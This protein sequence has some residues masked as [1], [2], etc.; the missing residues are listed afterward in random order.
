MD[1]RKVVVGESKPEL[2]DDEA[3]R[4][5]HR[6]VER[7]LEVHSSAGDS[8]ITVEVR[9]L[10]RAREVDPAI[11]FRKPRGR[12]ELGKSGVGKVLRRD[13]PVQHLV[14]LHAPAHPEPGSGVDEIRALRQVG[15]GAVRE[16]GAEVPQVVVVGCPL[17]VD[18]RR[19]ARG[20]G[21]VMPNRERGALVA[22]LAIVGHVL[23]RHPPAPPGHQVAVLAGGLH[24]AFVQPAEAESRVPVGS[25]VEVVGRAELEAV[26]IGNP[27]SGREKAGAAGVAQRE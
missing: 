11:A 17:V 10:R 7:G 20:E 21:A 22:V 15:Q 23:T 14:V 3:G 16:V 12:E 19:P 13:V 24:A 2:R 27:G 8:E 4:T 18:V 26:R 25:E 9:K 5:T 1:I 6:K